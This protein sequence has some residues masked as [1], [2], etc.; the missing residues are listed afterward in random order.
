MRTAILIQGLISILGSAVLLFSS[1]QHAASYFSGSILIFLNLLLLTWVWNKVL[2]KKLIALSA[3]IIVFKYAIFAVVIYK[4][5]SL[6]WLHYAWFCVGLS[7]LIIT[8]LVLALLGSRIREQ[9]N[10]S[11]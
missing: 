6:A 2:Q 9:Q 7:T 1:T 11:E 8:V 5:T 3:L 10:L 4:I